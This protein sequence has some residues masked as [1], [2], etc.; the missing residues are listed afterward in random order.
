MKRRLFPTLTLLLA[1]TLFSTA[2]AIHEDSGSNVTPSSSFHYEDNEEYD[3]NTHWLW[4]VF[5][6]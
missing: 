2:L 4:C 1:L 6:L 3:C 5:G